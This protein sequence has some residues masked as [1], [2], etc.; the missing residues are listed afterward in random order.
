MNSLDRRRPSLGSEFASNRKGL[1]GLILVGASFGGLGED[2]AQGSVI[3]IVEHLQKL[4]QCCQVLRVSFQDMLE[5]GDFENA[6]RL[7]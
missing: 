3:G 1:I 6:S 5:L 4:S 2:R 7:K